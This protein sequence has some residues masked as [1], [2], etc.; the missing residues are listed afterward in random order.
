MNLEQELKQLPDEPGV[1]LFYDT[2]NSVIYIGKASSLAK[3][4]PAHF[5]GI[6]KGHIISPI[7]QETVDIEYVITGTEAE[8]L[9]LEDNLIKRHKPRYN[10]R[11]KDDKSFPYVRITL[12]EDFPRI[13]KTR[14]I[15]NDGS[16]YIGP[17]AN[18][19]ALNG[20]LKSIIRVVP[21]A[22]CGQKIILGKR[23][24]PCLK[25]DIGQCPGPC[26]G[27]VSIDEYA[28][29]VNQF[30]LM[31]TGQ[32]E[33][34]EKQLH[35][36]MDATSKKQEYEKAAI[37]R[38]RLRAVQRGRQ[39]QRATIWNQLPGHRDVIGIARN[40]P[41]AMVQLLVV[42]SGRIV[43][44]QPFPL[45]APSAISDEMVLE[46]FL[47]QYYMRATE[48]PEEII[49][50]FTLHDD[51]FL[52]KWLMDRKGQSVRIIR[53]KSGPRVSL[54]EM[55][56]ENAEFH[57]HHLI[58]RLAADEG[59]RARAYQD[60]IETLVLP[61]EPRAIEGFDVSTLQG[62]D[63]VGVC[64][65]FSEGMPV[66]KQYRRFKIR[67]VEGQDDFAM[68]HEVVFRRYKR[69]I[70]EGRQLP[71]LILID[72]GR[73]QLNMALKALKELNAPDIHVIGLAKGTPPEP[74]FVFLPGQSAPL[75]LSKDSQGLRLLQRVRDEAHRF[76]ISYHRKLRQK[77][78]LKLVLTDIPGV[79]FRRASLLMQHFGS[80]KKIAQASIEELAAVPHVNRSLAQTILSNLKDYQT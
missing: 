68:I 48:I 44:Q 78:G 30:V 19:K 18:V 24:R 46:A 71:D 29:S 57:L 62:S 52:K 49:I 65:V 10:V 21:I 37:F 73:G 55:A 20:L 9:V 43:G 36:L 26:V 4:V 15:V 13:E 74:D 7:G 1:Y 76:A 51:T 69:Q 60:L 40:G 47:K 54:I 42:R 22:T 50:P 75:H 31:L 28:E 80:I 25:Y 61:K 17:F 2:T 12:S 14:T 72:G 32:H 34:L 39:A 23:K 53:P 70:A 5:R 41:D 38:D 35:T 6:E 45:S 64:V 66:K 8:A 3:R 63:S 56:N 33:E 11:L 77:R 79:G 58:E 16:R 59:R 27:K 67:Q